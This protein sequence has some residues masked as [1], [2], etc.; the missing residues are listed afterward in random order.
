MVSPCTSSRILK[1]ALS[2]GKNEQKQVRPRHQSN[3]LVLSSPGGLI[4]GG[5]LGNVSAIG[6]SVN[7]Y[8]DNVSPKWPEH[9]ARDTTEIS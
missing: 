3:G 7:T 2:G 9:S 5:S 4:K 8:L 1:L 6:P